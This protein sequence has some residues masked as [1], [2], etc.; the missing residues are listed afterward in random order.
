MWIDAKGNKLRH[1]FMRGMMRS[2]ARLTY[3]Q[4][5]RAMDGEPDDRAAPLVDTVIKPLYGAYHALRAAREA[6]GALDLDLPERRI[7]MRKNGTIAKIELRENL[8]SH[9]LIE[10][11]M[12]AANVS[13]AET[14]EQHEQPCMYRVHETPDPDRVENLRTV[15]DSIGIKLSRG[16][17]LRAGDFNHIVEKA[18]ATPHSALVSEAVL[19]CQSQAAYSPD[20][21]GH[22]GL[23]LRK[24]A[25]FTS[26]IRRYSDLLVHRALITGLALGDGGLGAIDDTRFHGI[27]QSI[28]DLERRAAA[29]ERD[30]ADRLTVAYL[31]D[32]TGAIF[33]AR[34]NG[35][36][37]FGAFVV[38]TETRANGL[39]PFSAL[40]DERFRVDEA[41]QALV[42]ARGRTVIRMGDALK[43]RLLEANPLTGSMIF[44]P[45][46]RKK[47]G[48]PGNK[49]GAR[50]R[51]GAKRKHRPS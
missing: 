36:T 24:Y 3:S 18:R 11:F 45:L 25:H 37:R 9:Q 35:I 39:I 38:L 31:A 4:V 21:L 16:N 50:K 47:G 46:N 1:E 12:I 17:V 51:K 33:D 6:R 7:T 48:K 14:L 26:P 8:D 2:S 15:L 32:R 10:E 28:S 44:E 41:R 43:V 30:A 23:G 42:G 20:N 19:R 49:P 34:V 40:G 5:Q 13:A 27:A 29:A 22:F